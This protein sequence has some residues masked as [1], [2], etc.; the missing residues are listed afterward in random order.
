MADDDHCEIAGNANVFL[1]NC[2]A[3]D[4]EVG[5]HDRI[6]ALAAIRGAECFKWHGDDLAAALRQLDDFADGSE[7]L[8]GHNLIRFDI[9]RLRAANANLRLLRLPVVDTLWLSPLAFPR[10][11]YHHLVKHYQDGQI[12]RGRV[13]D[14]ELDAKLSLEVAG[15]QLEAL[16]ETHPDLL[17]VWHWLTAAGAGA[18]AAGAGFDAYFASLRNAPR[19]TEPEARLAIASQLAKA[20]CLVAGREVLG[21]L[22]QHGWP[23]AFA[24]AWLSVAGGNSVMPPW[25]RHQ[26]ADAGALVRRLRDTP[27]KD[28]GCLW[29]QE[30]HNAKSELKRWF[31]YAAFRAKPQ[32]NDGQ[33]MQ[34]AIVEAALGGRHLLG[35]LPTGVGKS[36]CYQV[37][38]LSRYDKTGALTVVISP[39]VALMADQVAGLA[40]RGIDSCVTVNGLLSMPERADALDRVRLGDASMLIIAPEQLRSRVVRQTI[41]QREIGI[42][43]LD[44]AHCLSKWGHD[45]RPDY[46]Y[47]ARFIRECA[48]QAAVLCLTATAKPDVKND[49]VEHF[50]EKLSVD[51]ELFDGGSERDNL[52]FV[53]VHTTAA[54]KFAH[55]HDLLTSRSLNE[56]NGP[57]GPA[58][59]AGGA[60][61]YCATRRRAENVA[62]F[63]RRHDINAAHFHAGLSPELKKDVQ[64]RFVNGGLPVIVATNAFG[65]GID[66]PDVRL[67]IHADLPGS[68]ENYLQ[69]AGRAGRDQEA[70]CC[71][72]LYSADDVER[73]FSLSA[74]SRLAPREIQAVL[75]ALR[76]LDRRKR[77][78]GEV[79]ATAGEI[80]RNEDDAAFERDSATDD[81]RVRTAISWLEDAE[82]LTREE[83][84]TQIF[85]S[86]LRV[87]SIEQARDK[88]ATVR[89]D[90]RQQLLHIVRTLIEADA[91]EGVSTDE[92]M[93]VCGLK[94]EGVRKAL[95]DLEALGIASNDTVLTAYVHQGVQRHSR[96]RFQETALLEQALIDNLQEVAPDMAKGDSHMLHLRVATQRL[97]DEGHEAL[98]EQVRSL[99]RSIERDGYGDDGAAGSIGLRPL[100]NESL[101]VTLN[102]EWPAL[103]KT[104]NLR[105]DAAQRLLAHLLDCLPPG[106]Q[107]TDLLAETTLGKLLHAVKSDME[108]KN[109]FKRPAKLV[110]RALLW[111]HEQQ[112]IRLNKGLTIFRPAMSIRLSQDRRRQFRKTDFEPLR[113]HYAD[114]VLQI[115][116]MAEYAQ[117]GLRQMA[118]AIRLTMDYFS[119]KQDEFLR[120]WMP[121]QEEHSR[122]TTPESW[123]RI[124]E[125]LAPDQRSIVVADDEQHSALV[126]A[127]PG[128][129]KTRVLVHRIAYLV[130]MRRE[131]PRSIVALAYNRHAAANIRRRLAELIGEDARG[132]AAHTCHGLAMRLVGASFS[133]GVNQPDDGSFKDVLRD[134]TALLRG[135][136]MPPEEADEQ[137]TRLLAGLRW[138]LVD[139][140]QDINDE[141][142]ALIAALAG[143]TSTDAD[144]KRHLLVVGDDD[145]N[146]YSFNG[147]SVKFIR[148][149]EQDYGA[150]RFFLAE[151][152]R[153]TAHIIKASNAVIRPAESRMKSEH[154][155]RPDRER[156]GEPAGGPWSELD[157]VAQG[158]VQLLPCPRDSIAQAQAALVA[159][160][161]LASCGNRNWDWAKC[162][163]I[164]REWRYLEP[165]RACCELLG[166]PVQMGNEEFRG[167]WRVR[168]IQAFVAW[169]R[170]RQDMVD[171]AASAAWLDE[172]PPTPWNDLLREALAEHRQESGAAPVPTQQC[173]EWLAEWSRDVR[174]RQRGLLLLTAH[175]AKGLEFDHVVVLDGGWEDRRDDE[176]RLYYVAMTRARHTL[177]LMCFDGP[178]R[179]RAPLLRSSPAPP[180]PPAPSTLHCQPSVLSPPT[181]AMANIWSRLNLKDV[182]LGFAGRRSIE[183][184]V[185]RHIRELNAGNCLEL[186]ENERWELFDRGVLV[187][188]LAQQY[189]PPAMNGQSGRVRARVAAIVTWSREISPA[190]YRNRCACDVWEVVVPE[191]VFS[192][193]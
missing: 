111:L 42:W 152:Y 3:L 126:L 193:A 87:H 174:R 112:I 56:P 10:H 95:H 86:S 165:V 9:P 23:L 173:I 156:V 21:A 115:H 151:N 99:L 29:C 38:A 176:R 25:V 157:P 116:V 167:L 19:P 20:V 179:L 177:A 64:D 94:P 89:G 143:R 65:M 147:A 110:D 6:Y 41:E 184:P 77:M 58:E 160:Q 8:L 161:R 67:V 133:A 33:S 142:Y 5:K 2:L 44:E 129:G 141:Q 139:E 28:A 16:R 7:A 36:L 52:D 50:R 192:K 175:R 39:L 150:K 79:V 66:K 97:K 26:F 109:R 76:N 163:V 171:A 15:D 51:L 73:Q 191:L 85:P 123:R 92:L 69:E 80:L 60:I 82:L 35:I 43:V 32:Y 46:R 134:A 70:A 106:S 166:I 118:A 178:N 162:A 181:S 172:R 11:P 74:R 31:G 136:G 63:L 13:N 101:R 145:Q 62:E 164:A 144:D 105:R 84:R 170:D 138:M 100:D 154:P 124:V 96:V 104:A 127:G 125:T 128:S 149:F 132:V 91:D 98:P 135:D 61:V 24:L 57:S 158:R 155:I 27:C 48:P 53:V 4:I 22:A 114:Q 108:L 14:P 37:P 93:G 78:N 159:L 146:V 30:R 81:S 47:V 117:R 153:S 45:F 49:I 119:L 186:R 140:F 71:V 54:E 103:A 182:D 131:D 121:S 75:R 12:R 102:R 183:D 148:Q 188:R 168:E 90:Y 34:Q 185:H 180:A 55:I 190:E 68:L 59:M 187:G 137:R 189:R 18:G 122:Q 88:L 120:R 107:G 40:K 72:L 130:R 113:L 169:L 17:I 83:N 1:R